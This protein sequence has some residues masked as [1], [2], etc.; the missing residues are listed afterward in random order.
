MLISSSSRVYPTNNFGHQN[1]VHFYHYQRY[2]VQGNNYN[3]Y[4]LH[5]VEVKNNMTNRN[6]E[7]VGWHMKQGR[8]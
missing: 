1:N 4:G 2:A 5:I 8:L 6:I 7:V 3:N